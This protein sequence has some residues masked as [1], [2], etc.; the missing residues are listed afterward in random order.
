MERLKS[1]FEQ[2]ETPGMP[3]TL[4]ELQGQ[5]QVLVEGHRGILGYSRKEILVKTREGVLH[6]AGEDLT[7]CCMSRE[8][9]FIRGRIAALVCEGAPS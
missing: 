5:Q 6:I 2:A 7:L 3:R 9:L 8:Q 4:V 1:I